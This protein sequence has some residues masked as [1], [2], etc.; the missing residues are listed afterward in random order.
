MVGSLP[1][2]LVWERRG[3]GPKLARDAG[4]RALRKKETD[5]SGTAARK[6]ACVVPSGFP[7]AV[8]ENK[9]GSFR[10]LVTNR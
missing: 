10:H 7:V 4:K 5:Y 6:A 9:M 1:A 3:P 8:P 2:R